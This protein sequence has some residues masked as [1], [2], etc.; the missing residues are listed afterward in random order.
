MEKIQS[1]PM[2]I[3]LS[4]WKPAFSVNLRR[5]NYGFYGVF[6]EINIL[7]RFPTLFFSAIL[8]IREISLRD[9]SL[10]LCSKRLPVSFTRLV[11]FR[12]IFPSRLESRLTFLSIWT[13]RLDEE[14][15]IETR[16]SSVTA[17]D[18][19]LVYM[20]SFYCFPQFRIVLDFAHLF[21][22]LY[23][24]IYMLLSKTGSNYLG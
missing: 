21:L 17:T 11:R 14:I 18:E 5:G 23:S 3:F 2:L 8:F 20:M 24:Y 7:L 13:G 6:D 16:N 10:L 4:A 22:F 1:D 15:I 9:S 12:T 19:F